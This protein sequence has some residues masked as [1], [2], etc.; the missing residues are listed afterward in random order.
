MWCAAS[1]M[2]RRSRS[3]AIS[4]AALADLPAEAMSGALHGMESVTGLPLFAC[5]GAVSIAF[6]ASAVPLLV[7]QHRQTALLYGPSA[8]P[9]H[10]LRALFLNDKDTPIAERVASYKKASSLI[11]RKIGY[12]RWKAWCNPVVQLPAFIVFISSLRTCLTTDPA[13]ATGGAFWFTNLSMRDS[14]FVLPVVAI[15]LSYVAVEMVLRRH[16]NRDHPV[17]KVVG[18]FQ[19]GMILSLP[20][21]SLIPSGIFM[22]WIPTSLW[23][24]AQT[25]LLHTPAIRQWLGYPVEPLR[26]PTVVA[27][28]NK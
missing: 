26:T 7:M 8:Q 5:I 14:T 4:V 6:R 23:T 13:M 27:A 28:T 1:M 18:W 20:F 24:I 19:T 9:L 11:L 16:A 12:S 21:V 17:V 25:H 22:Y 2:M 15:S 10:M 3:R